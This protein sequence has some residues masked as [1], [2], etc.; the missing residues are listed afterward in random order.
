M[1]VVIAQAVTLCGCGSCGCLDPVKRACVCVCGG[2]EDLH[3]VDTGCRTRCLYID[4]DNHTRFTIGTQQ[5]YLLLFGIPSPTHS[6]ILGLKP[7]F[8]ANPFHRSPSF[9]FFRI[10]YMDSPDCL[11]LLLSIFCLLLFTFSVFTLFS[12][13][14]RAV[15]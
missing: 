9:S 12:C 11:L 7:S 3:T 15:D 13:R 6:F 4:M 5:S 10:H 2:R 14:F 8:A 1:A